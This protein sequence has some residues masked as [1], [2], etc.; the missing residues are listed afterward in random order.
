M[1]P[2]GRIQAGEQS[3]PAPLVADLGEQRCGQQQKT[4]TR[5]G[6]TRSGCWVARVVAAAASTRS[7]DSIGVESPR[8]PD[9]NGPS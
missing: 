6:S 8:W 1:W 2:G 3:C 9:A 7:G 4:T 5:G